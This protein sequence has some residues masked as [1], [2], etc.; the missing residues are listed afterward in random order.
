MMAD[1]LNSAFMRVST[2]SNKSVS[3]MNCFENQKINRLKMTD[4]VMVELNN[5]AN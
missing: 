5:K 1:V 3:I 2:S 4:L